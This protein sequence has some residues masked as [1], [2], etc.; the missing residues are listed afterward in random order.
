MESSGSIIH[1][2]SH[3][4]ITC[5][6]HPLSPSLSPSQGSW[7]TVEKDKLFCLL[8]PNGAGKSTTINCLTGIIGTTAGDGERHSLS[9]RVGAATHQFFFLPSRS[10][11]VSEE[12]SSRATIQSSMPLTPLASQSGPHAGCTLRLHVVVPMQRC[13]ELSA[14]Q[15]VTDD[16]SLPCFFTLSSFPSATL[17]ALCLS[18][19][20]PPSLS[21]SFSSP[22]SGLVYGKS[23]RNPSSMAAIRSQM[24]VCPQV[25]GMGKGV[26]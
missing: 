24:G 21:L 26:V 1:T 19:S 18:L 11:S 8:G 9:E 20:L 14:L 23:I 4:P 22:P 13:W 25:R 15:A 5:L 6:S 3:P 12:C 7:F 16:S 2:S 10:S 17:R